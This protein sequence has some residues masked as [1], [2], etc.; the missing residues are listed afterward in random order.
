MFKTRPHPER[1]GGGGGQ[2][3]KETIR[4]KSVELQVHVC[5]YIIAVKDKNEF[6]LA[7]YSKIAKVRF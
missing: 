2:G 7:V 3:R 6:Y 5:V 1:G 4:F